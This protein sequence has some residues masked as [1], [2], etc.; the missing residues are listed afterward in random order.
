MAALGLG[1]RREIERWIEQGR[2]VVDG[3]PAMLGQ[4]ISGSEKISFDGRPVRLGRVPLVHEHLIY[5]KPIGEL[6][7]RRDPEGRRTVFESLPAPRR[8]R[9]VGVG[10]LDINTAGLLLFTTDG[11]LAHRLMH[12]RY[13]I[14]RE[15]AVRVLG[16]GLDEA[17]LKQLTTGVELEDGCACFDRIEPAGG[18]GANVWYRVVLKEGRNREVRRI[19]E[20]LGITVSRLIRV[21]YGPVDLGKL[22]RGETRRLGE[23][24]IGALYVAVGLERPP[25]AHRVKP[26]PQRRRKPR[27]GV[28]G[29][30][31]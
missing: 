23:E 28:R 10:R 4:P 31:R 17:T 14:A 25:P 20:A 5:H 8:G 16:G 22:K 12:P 1:S 6:T 7:S 3:K 15:Y 9:W 27:R 30:S 13:E 21:A 26:K 18:A 24:E 29:A 11:E 19:F 2:L